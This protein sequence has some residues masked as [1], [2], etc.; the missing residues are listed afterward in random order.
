MNPVKEILRKSILKGYR[1]IYSSSVNSRLGF[2]SDEKLLIIHADDLGLNATENSATISAFEN[3]M[4]NSGSIMVPCRGYD[5]IVAYLRSNPGHDVGVHLTLTSE[6]EAYRWGPVTPAAEV[7][8]LVGPDACFH[9]DKTT[10]AR[11]A[12]PAEIEK[13]LRTQIETLRADGV[14]ITHLDS[15][16]FVA[17]A[18]KVLKIYEKLGREYR[19][20][21][22]LTND[23]PL[24]FLTRNN[25]FTVDKLAY[26]RGSDYKGNLNDFYAGVIRSLKPGLT[27]ILI[28]VA[29][30]NSEMQAM[31]GETLSFGSKWRQSDYDFFTGTQCRNLISE[32][33]IRLITWREIGERLYSRKGK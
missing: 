2:G 11:L 5:E 23:L 33:G 4:V 25:P 22:L 29:Y 16:M 24:G 32:N 27:C 9:R 28:H 8:G 12:N 3:G 10:M 1:S 17:F 20:P 26:A 14:E 15:H 30:D 6:W 7:P 31:T 19:L 21:V 18:P 13:E